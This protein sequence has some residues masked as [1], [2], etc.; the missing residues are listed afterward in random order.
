LASLSNSDLAKHT[1]TRSKS[2]G[3][4]VS[5]NRQASCHPSKILAISELVPELILPSV[6]LQGEVSQKIKQ[7]KCKENYL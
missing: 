5:K 7:Q 3:F 2:K 4:G 1:N 6:S